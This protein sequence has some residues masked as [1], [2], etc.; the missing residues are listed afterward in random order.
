M[1]C[2]RVRRELSA[3]IDGELP[4][5]AAGAVS[6]HLAGCPACAG[7]AAELQ[8]VGRL[9][10][11]LPR[12]DPPESIAPRV[13][14][15]LE[16][17]TGGPALALLLRRGLGAAR[18]F[19]MPSLVPAALVLV[20][21]LAA[22]LALDSGSP[23]SLPQAAGTWRVGGPSGT[24]ANPLFPSAGVQLPR[25]RKGGGLLPEVLARTGEGT[26]FLET[27]VARDGTV[28]GVTILDGDSEAAG[29][30][31]DALWRQ[32]FEPVRYRG[33]PVAVSVYRLI[34]QMEV[35]SPVT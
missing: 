5:T 20:T 17:E 8:A 7:R 22:A 12:L 29:A 11:E 9:L 34:S 19:M 1:T 14:D 28:A 10:G 15:R 24:E 26:L 25:E 27:V 21:V 31:V 16:L 4:P 35:R 32:R 30:I 23:G 6:T 18:P 3:W 33:R 13:C 2:A